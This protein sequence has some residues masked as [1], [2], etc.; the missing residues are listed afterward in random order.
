MSWQNHDRGVGK[1]LYEVLTA[2]D[3]IP[4]PM[5]GPRIDHNLFRHGSVR[6]SLQRDGSC[7]WSRLPRCDCHATRTGGRLTRSSGHNDP[8]TWPEKLQVSVML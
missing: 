2:T 4:L 8:I 5:T 3:A 1:V 6:P 7:T